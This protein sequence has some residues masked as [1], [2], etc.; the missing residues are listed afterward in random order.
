MLEDLGIRLPQPG[1]VPRQ[2]E[3]ERAFAKAV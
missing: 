2:A 1:L 3:A